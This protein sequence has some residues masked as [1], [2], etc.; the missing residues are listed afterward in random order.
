MTKLNNKNIDVFF[1]RHRDIKR[2]TAAYLALP[3]AVVTDI[4]HRN[5]SVFDF[6][7]LLL[8]SQPQTRLIKNF[9][10]KHRQEVEAVEKFNSIISGYH[11]E[12]KHK[13]DSSSRV[14][15]LISIMQQLRLN[16][17]ELQAYLKNSR[18]TCSETGASSCT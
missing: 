8:E 11:A 2:L 4:I 9:L 12:Q 14:Y 6:M 13:E 10:E 18:F 7:N 16:N 17:D 1:M 3:D 15:L 5:L